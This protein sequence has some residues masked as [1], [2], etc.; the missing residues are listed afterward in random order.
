MVFIAFVEAI[1]VIA[2]E[3]VFLIRS[4]FYSVI[5][6]DLGSLLNQNPAEISRNAVNLI[7]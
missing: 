2:A 1:K 6:T 3:I 5:T 4:L 7:G